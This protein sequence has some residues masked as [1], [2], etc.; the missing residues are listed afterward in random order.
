M[1]NEDEILSKV[2]EVT[3]GFWVIKSLPR[4]SG[5]RAAMQ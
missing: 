5:R 4:R 2:P 1:Q 3:I